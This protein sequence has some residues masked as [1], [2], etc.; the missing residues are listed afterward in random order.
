M[1]KKKFFIV[2]LLLLF[3]IKS[4]ATHIV[5]GEIYYDCLGGNDYLVTLKVYRDCCPTCAQFDYPASIGVYDFMGNVVQVLTM[6]PSDSAYIPASLNDPCLT[7]PTNV[8]VQEAL[9]STVVN[10]PPIPGGYILSYQR[11]CRNSAIINILNASSVG[12]TYEAVILDDTIVTCNSTPRYTN[13]PPLF[14]CEGVPF[15]FDHSATDPDGDSLYY[16]LCTPYEGATPTMPMPVPPSSPPYNFVTYNAPY[17][18]SY[19][20]SSSPAL[21]LDPLTGILTG[22]PNMIGRFVVGVCVSEYRNGQLLTTNKRDFQFNIVN[23]PLASVSSIPNQT[24]F[25]TGYTMQFNQTSFNAFA[26][27]WDFGDPTTLADTSDQF[28]PTWTYADSGTYVVT[29]IVNPGTLCADTGSNVFY[30]YPLLDPAFTPPP[31]ECLNSNSFD[32]QA[33]GDFMGNGTFVWD[34]GTHASPNNITQQDPQG[35]TFDSTG[36]FPV[37]L[38]VSEN[39]CVESYTANIE[40]HPHPVAAYG[41]ASTIACDL[42]PVQFLDSSIS[43]T[44]LSYLWIFGDETT[45]TIQNPWHLFPAVGNYNTSLIVTDANGCTDTNSIVSPL[46]VYPSPEAAFDISPDDTSIFYPEVTMV[47]QSNGAISC[48]AFWGDGISY[49]NCDSIHS[50][51]APGTYTVMQVVTNTF[52]CKDTAYS[53]VLIRPEFLFWIPN[54]FTPNDNGLNEIFRPI[55]MGV[56]DYRFMIF[57]RWGERI[58]ETT[59]ELE[60]WDGRIKGR[61]CTNDVYVYK[62]TL[63]DDVTNQ[64]HVYIGKVT[65]V[66]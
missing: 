39:G 14:L 33:G 18:G 25:C 54:A 44:A 10:L 45:A 42:Q 36:T 5:G 12:S 63:R 64:E 4:N 57:D 58:F 26:Y 32:F 3:S 20:M 21:S 34:F 49:Q 51:T 17:S 23:C 13:F 40:V 52:G 27:H 11:C 2:C 35:I 30:I 62:I 46:V 29:L 50:Y 65:L 60:G 16:Q 43:Q 28:A 56:H 41:F 66:R 59:D 9:Y 19:P 37:T 22:T 31:G 1:F 53:T 38:T 61:I 47:D 55:M 6:S 7:P 15:V 8:C 24:Q 48:S